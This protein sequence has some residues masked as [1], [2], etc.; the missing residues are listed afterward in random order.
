MKSPYIWRFQ[1]Y[2]GKQ[3]SLVGSHISLVKGLDDICIKTFITVA[4]QTMIYWFGCFY[5]IYT[6]LDS[7]PGYFILGLEF[8]ESQS[9][10]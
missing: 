6:L 8:P 7:T 10:K 4:S 1:L 3:R 9:F 5:E 2:F